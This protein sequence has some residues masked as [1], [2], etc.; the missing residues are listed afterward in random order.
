MACVSERKKR[1]ANP[2]GR[3]AFTQ[4][5]L[6]SDKRQNLGVQAIGTTQ[7]EPYVGTVPSRA[8][9]GR[10]KYGTILITPMG[11]RKG[12]TQR[13]L[14]SSR[15][16]PP[17]VVVVSWSSVV[18]RSWFLGYP[19]KKLRI[20]K[21]APNLRKCRR[22]LEKSVLFSGADQKQ[23]PLFDGTYTICLWDDS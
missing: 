16:L 7:I 5:V 3:P 10:P 12:V 2:T 9:V 6:H 23:W 15:Q 14:T 20:S 1:P 18:S 8:V 13:I 19:P 21:K 17:L 11:L 4:R 22:K